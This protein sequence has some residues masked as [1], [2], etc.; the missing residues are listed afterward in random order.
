[1]S[2]SSA[3]PSTNFGSTSDCIEPKFKPIGNGHTDHHLRSTT[4]GFEFVRTLY[5]NEIERIACDVGDGE[6]SGISHYGLGLSR[7]HQRSFL[8]PINVF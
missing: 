7:V 2:G 8:A 5:L 1:M 6:G 3:E 4:P